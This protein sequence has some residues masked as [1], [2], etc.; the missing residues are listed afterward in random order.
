MHGLRHAYAQRRFEEITG[1]KAPLV[2]G[3]HRPALSIDQRALDKKARAVISGELGHER[4]A[5][6]KVYCG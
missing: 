1:F 5:I 6:T 3:P 4:L 2:G